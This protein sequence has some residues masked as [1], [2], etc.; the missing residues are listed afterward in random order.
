M[1]GTHAEAQHMQTCAPTSPTQAYAMAFDMPHM[2]QGAPTA[3]QLK[4][5]SNTSKTVLLIY[6]I[7]PLPLSPAGTQSRLHNLPFFPFILTTILWG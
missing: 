2:L 7:Y 6:I 4:T 5:L 1:E 3:V